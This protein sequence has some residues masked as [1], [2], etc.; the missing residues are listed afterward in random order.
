MSAKLDVAPRKIKS[1]CY[2]LFITSRSRKFVSIDF[3]KMYK[4]LHSNF[5]KENEYA[6]NYFKNSM[7]LKDI[8]RYETV[9]E[10]VLCTFYDIS[11]R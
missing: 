3:Q 2:N 6:Y 8:K 5:Q 9:Q 7:L 1:V 10:N 11:R 4:K